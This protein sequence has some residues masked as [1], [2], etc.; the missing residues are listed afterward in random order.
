MKHRLGNRE[1]VGGEAG[2]LPAGAETLAGGGL[3]TAIAE[4][5]IAG[6]VVP[7][8]RPTDWRIGGQ[9]QP[10]RFYRHAI[11]FK[12]VITG[13]QTLRVVVRRKTD[14]VADVAGEVG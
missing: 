14:E 8:R 10:A 13:K 6:L 12:I 9:F 7:C 3:N 11:E 5:E 2:G 1:A 4:E